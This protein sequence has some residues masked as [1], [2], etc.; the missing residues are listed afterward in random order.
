MNLEW[1]NTYGGDGWERINDAVLTS[2]TGTILV[3]ETSSNVTNNLDIYIVRTNK[4]GD[5]ILVY[6]HD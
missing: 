5:T 2:D 6:F 4:F 3:G 1:D